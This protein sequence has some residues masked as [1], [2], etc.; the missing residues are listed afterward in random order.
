MPICETDLQS[1]I[2]LLETHQKFLLIPHDR[3]DGDALGSMLA[4]SRALTLHG[5]SPMPVILGGISERYQ[6]LFPHTCPPVVE[7]DLAVD[8]IP[9]PD[10]IVV[11]DTGSRQQLGPVLSFLD[12]HPAPIVVIDHHAHGNICPDLAL[13]DEGSPATGLL[14]A[15]LLTEMNWLDDAEIASALLIAIAT[16]TGWFSYS[17]TNADCFDWATRLVNRGAD[18]RMIYE[19]LFLSDSPARFRLLART[20]ASAELRSDDRLVVLSLTRDDFR[21]CGADEAHTENLVDQ[22]C[23]VKSMQ[24]AALFVEQPGGMVRISLRSREPFDVH[25]FSVQ[26]GG[27]GHHRAAGMKVQGE[28]QEV[29]RRVTLALEA[30]LAR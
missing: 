15:R 17:N 25:R 14:M 26:F 1:V 21:M 20:L 12:R 6:F 22:A 18:A 27:G 28:F 7:K 4:L 23:R 13:T 2:T 3:P 11:I 5:K 30:E 9:V 16:D 19:K 10:V 29:K 24:V 8:S